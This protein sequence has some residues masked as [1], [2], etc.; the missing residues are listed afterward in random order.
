MQQQEV[1]DMAERQAVVEIAERAADD[2]GGLLFGGELAQL[3]RSP[4]HPCV[5]SSYADCSGHT[6]TTPCA[7]AQGVA[8]TSFAASSA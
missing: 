3:D 7:T 1:D 8:E 6:S 2:A 4:S 5:G